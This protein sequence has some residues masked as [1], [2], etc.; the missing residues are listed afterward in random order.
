[1]ATQP[2]P[3]QILAG[4]QQASGRT[5]A[6]LLAYGTALWM[7]LGSYR[8]SDIDKFV[9]AIVPKVLAGQLTIANLT[10]VYLA[11]MT[12]H[13]AVAAS[14]A[15]LA[16]P[17]AVGGNLGGAVP[18]RG[19]VAPGPRPVASAPG[20]QA[21]AKAAEP[22]ASRTI[23][24][25]ERNLAESVASRAARGP[26]PVDAK[27]IQNGRGVDPT[28][29][30]RRPAAEVYRS[31]A[32]GSTFS[33]S[34]SRGRDRLESLIATDL[35]MAKVR[36]AQTSLERSHAK[37][38]RRVLRGDKNCAKCV[39]TS[40]LRYRKSQLL[41]IHPGCV[42]EGSLVS[43]PSG[44]SGE[45]GSFAWGEVQ[46][47]T[48]R[49]FDGEL[50]EFA[51]AGGDLVRVTPNHPVLTEQGWIPADLLREGHT[52]FRSVAGHRM[53]DGRPQVDQRP[54]LIEDVFHAARMAFPL[55]R[56]P[57]AAEDFHADA[58]EGE[59]DVVYTD[60]LFPAEWN[61]HR[62][63]VAG[64]LCLVDAHL[65]WAPFD[66]GSSLG[67]LLPGG[68]P[69]PGRGVSGGGLGHA[70]VGGHGGGPQLPGGAAGAR[71]DAP[72]DKFSPENAAIY[73]QRGLDLI[74]RLTGRV[75][76]DRIVELR[77]IRW[78]GHVFN[79]HTREGW[80]VSN[81]RIVSNCDCDVE[82]IFDADTP[83][84][85][86]EKLLRDTH[87]Q[88]RLFAGINNA[89]AEGYQNLVVTHQHGEIGPVM[90]WRHQKFA[91]P[92]R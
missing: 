53:V 60:G 13:P 41:P 40:T 55:V 90:A 67:A 82:P 33:V 26:I 42:P 8:D 12:A 76:G 23:P 31:L 88:V 49:L 17:P 65:G 15:R 83:L 27:Q 69:T 77:R 19:P 22:L 51:T 5:R 87:E 9:A 54:A 52:V 79:L 85:L 59:V 29:V 45:P 71:F 25:S 91:G 34:V 63:E 1:M 43:V 7:G 3:E 39:I 2:T 11:K 35:Q 61:S 86:D 80:Y 68:A 18:A 84:V 14:S 28:E 73:A 56:V 47:V 38:Y 50:V 70:L 44:E 10:S 72:A 32:E 58:A 78:T 66:G 92:T 57:L 48:R 4:Y 16:N 64:E 81:N 89:S 30:Y 62:L 21:V 74:G 46:A 75:A 6:Q 37:F 24:G 36:Q 20:S